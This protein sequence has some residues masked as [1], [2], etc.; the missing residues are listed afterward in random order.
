MF[1]IIS[2]YNYINSFISSYISLNNEDKI[3][4]KL[5]SLK[6]INNIEKSINNYITV[7]QYLDVIFNKDITTKYKKKQEGIRPVNIEFDIVEELGEEEMELPPKKIKK[8]II[9]KLNEKTVLL[10]EPEQ[11]QIEIIPV[12]KR[13]KQTKMLKVNP[14]GKRKTKRLLPE[15]F[16]IF[17]EA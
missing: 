10:E 15:D 1:D 2:G 16:V 4:I 14:P 17:N 13:K 5:T 12:I 11:E 6:E 7:E 9:K 3:E 8:R